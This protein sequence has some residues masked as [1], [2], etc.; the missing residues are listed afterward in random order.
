MKRKKKPPS[1]V[2]YDAE[3]PV[4]SFRLSL[5]LKERLE[6]YIS[7]KGISYAD[8]IKETLDVREER[9]EAVWEEGFNEGY[10]AGIK[11]NRE[12]FEELQQSVV[13]VQNGINQF[14]EYIGELKRANQSLA[15]RNKELEAREA[16]MQKG[17]LELT[18]DELSDIGHTVT[19]A[20]LIKLY[21]LLDSY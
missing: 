4:V 9:D 3:H 5:E 6:D 10:D 8:Y 21:R 18:F 15:I 1:K 20:Q 19:K 14:K 16:S 12:K 7:R 13:K 2:K 17:Y 11:E